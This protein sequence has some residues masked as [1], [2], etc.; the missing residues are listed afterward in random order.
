MTPAQ[1]SVQAGHSAIQFQHEHSEI[2]KKW[3]KESLYL[4][5]LSVENKE[6][7][8]KLISKLEK[9]QIKFSAFIEPDMGGEI[10][11]ICLE[12]SDKTRRITSS[13]PLMLRNKFEK[14]E[15]TKQ[16]NKKGELSYENVEFT[17]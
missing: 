17:D 10:T 13:L 2:S 7:L 9:S 1:Q 15:S 12:P 5:Y 14:I 8:L 16:N 3:F 4:V 11:S 6:E